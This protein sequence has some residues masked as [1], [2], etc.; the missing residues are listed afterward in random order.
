[1]KKEIDKVNG[2]Y[3]I[4]SNG[5]YV[6]LAG[7]KLRVFNTDGSQIICRDDIRY[8]GRITFLSN[9]RM[10]LSTGNGVIHLID[11]VT[12]KDIW[13]V[14]GPKADLNIIHFAITPD[15]T[16]AYTFGSKK[17]KLFI[18]RVDLR[19]HEVDNFYVT[20]NI[21]STND[22]ACDE[23]GVACILKSLYQNVAGQTI[24][25]NGVLIQDYDDSSRGNT[26]YWKSKW[27]FLGQKK[28]LCFWGDIDHILT[29]D[30]SLYEP[31]TGNNVNLLEKDN[32]NIAVSVSPS[33]AWLTTDKRYLCLKYLHSN[34]IIDVQQKKI[35][36]LYGVEYTRG[37][38]VENEYWIC[39]GKRIIRKPFP[40]VEAIIKKNTTAKIDE[41]MG[42]HPELW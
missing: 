18:I 15:E 37:C 13:S 25:E 35:C 26:H 19:N 7:T 3:D 21:G 2:Y 36:A 12:G 5:R 22:I 42:K 11:L 10:M 6:V 28:A 32:V 29:T 1:M 34:M 8:P 39:V 38:I 41:Y 14:Q 20:D 24:S 27:Q 33:E 9:N 40:L 4:Y 23:N 31:L 17:D 30:L 16:C